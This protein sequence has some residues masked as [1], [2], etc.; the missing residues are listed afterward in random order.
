MERS[1]E[2]TVTVPGEGTHVDLDAKGDGE[3]E[4]Y[5][6]L[7]G[8]VR[9]RIGGGPDSPE[10]GPFAAYILERGTRLSDEEVAARELARL[11]EITNRWHVTDDEQYMVRLFHGVDP[12]RDGGTVTVRAFG[13][14]GSGQ[15]LGAALKALM[16]ACQPTS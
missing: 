10:Y 8:A 2:F 3:A 1:H 14:E 7:L 9:E 12:Q 6:E 15:Q 4:V 16:G 5:R 11:R 13:L